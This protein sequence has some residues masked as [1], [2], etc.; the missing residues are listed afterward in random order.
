ML[1][2]ISRFARSRR[3][4]IAM[5]T[6]I[7]AP[8]L[9]AI[10]GVAID[11]VMMT[12]IRGQL[13]AAADAAALAGVKELSLS[14]STQNQVKAVAESF[15]KDNLEDLPENGGKDGA[16]SINIKIAKEKR[17]VD[18]AIRKEWTPFFLHFVANGVTPIAAHAQATT[19]GLRLACVLGLA[20]LVPPGVQLWSNA[21]LLGRWLRC[22]QQYQN[23]TRIGRQRQCNPQGRPHLRERRLRC[24]EPRCR[25]TQADYRLPVI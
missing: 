22:L 25:G 13:Q 6:A 17:T 23:P 20:P 21:S 3:G 24:P 18:V 12:H 7:C 10:V 2:L 9:L 5:I 4:S 16:L 15:A 1:S 14:G 11:Y 19:M 8:A